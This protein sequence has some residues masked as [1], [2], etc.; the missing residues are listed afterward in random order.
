MSICSG[1]F[2][3]LTP[4]T[5]GE[6]HVRIF[7]RVA[8]YQRRRL[9]NFCLFCL[10][11]FCRAIILR[12]GEVIPMSTE[13]TPESERQR[14]QF[15]VRINPSQPL[16]G[17]HSCQILAAL[18]SPPAETPATLNSVSH[19]LPALFDQGIVFPVPRTCH[20]SSFSLPLFFPLYIKGLHAAPLIRERVYTSG[21]PEESPE[22]GGG[23]ED[24]VP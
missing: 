18:T 17:T 1:S 24:A 8:H 2:T 9:N 16:C 20:P 23:E 7:S 15:L 3:L 13:F 4:G 21:V 10:H 14:L 19:T 11:L 12:A 5:A 6:R 22:E